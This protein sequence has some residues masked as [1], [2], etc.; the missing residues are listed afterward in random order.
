M[1]LSAD[2]MT[3]AHKVHTYADLLQQIRNDLRI[4][5]PEWIKPN[6]QCPTCDS[7]EARLIELLD[8]SIPGEPDVVQNFKAQRVPC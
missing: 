3:L 7:Y 5:H 8:A 6:G 4:Q 2:S 1:N